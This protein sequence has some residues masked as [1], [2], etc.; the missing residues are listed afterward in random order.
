MRAIRILIFSTLIPLLGLAAF[1]ISCLPGKPASSTETTEKKPPGDL[2]L[3][4]STFYCE[5]KI[6]AVDSNTLLVRIEKIIRQGSA[7]F[8]P[9]SAGD[10]VTVKQNSLEQWKPLPGSS[11]A[12]LIE[13]RL[14]LNAEKPDF[15]LRQAVSADN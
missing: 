3:T 12:M 15:I 8:Y 2:S 13:E 4:P 1:T 11:K 6:L 9:V 14:R 10:T 7:L 5:G